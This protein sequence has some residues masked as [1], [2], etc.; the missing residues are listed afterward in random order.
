M[1]S[2]VNIEPYHAAGTAQDA[3][4]TAMYKTDT[5]HS[6]CGMYVAVGS[7]TLN[8]MNK[9]S[10]FKSSKCWEAKIKMENEILTRKVMD[11]P[12]EEVVFFMKTKKVREMALQSTRDRGNS[13]C[14]GPEVLSEAARRPV[15]WRQFRRGP[16]RDK[17]IGLRGPITEG[18]GSTLGCTLSEIGRSRKTTSS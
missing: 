4:N 17:V 12:T 7:Q 10:V 1:I 13:R 5:F 15:G 18:P 6:P 8:K 16:V 9:Y 2:P 11:D 14:K 3:R